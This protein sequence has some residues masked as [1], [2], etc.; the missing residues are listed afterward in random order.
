MSW[1]VASDGLGGD[2]LVGRLCKGV[3][4]ARN[5][6]DGSRRND[7]RREKLSWA[8]VVVRLEIAVGIDC[9]KPCILLPPMQLSCIP[10]YLLITFSHE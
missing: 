1:R 8:S 4:A 9:V 2:A 5:G 10:S 3:R 6:R 7:G